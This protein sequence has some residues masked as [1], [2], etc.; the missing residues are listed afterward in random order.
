M[1]QWTMEGY[2]SLLLICFRKF[3]FWLWAQKMCLQV[4]INNLSPMKEAKF[5][6]EMFSEFAS[7]IQMWEY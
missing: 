7:F 3:G 4:W 1:S 2:H 5:A 6:P